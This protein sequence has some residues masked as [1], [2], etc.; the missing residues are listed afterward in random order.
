MSI[1]NKGRSFIQLNQQINFKNK[2][3]FLQ[4]LHGV[5]D[6]YADINI[7]NETNYIILQLL[8]L[9]PNLGNVK[10]LLSNIKLFINIDVYYKQH[11][12][13]ISILFHK[14]DAFKILHEI[15]N[16]KDIDYTYNQTIY[17]KFHNWIAG[18]NSY[19]HGLISNIEH[20]NQISYNTKMV[21][22]FLLGWFDTNGFINSSKVQN[23]P[24]ITIECI[25]KDNVSILYDLINIRGTIR[26]TKIHLNGCNAVDFLS[27]IYD[28]Y[29]E[30]RFFNKDKYNLYLEWN[31]YQYPQERII[32][33]SF[34]KDDV[35]AV[36]PTKNRHS[37]VG[38][39]LTIIKKIKNISD[40]I[41]MYDTG[42][43]VQPEYGY[44]TKIVP[45]SSIV[46]TGYILANSVGIIDGNFTGTLK[47]VL[48]KID[49]SM[50]DIV[51]PCKIAQL[52]IDKSIHYQMIEESNNNLYETNRGSGEFG[53]TNKL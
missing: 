44:Y 24:E 43:I 38:Y 30:T 37:D 33:C 34:Y 13:F 11:N 46:K 45:R 10:Q 6:T 12:K 4:F 32:K 40:D 27:K 49:K 7:R 35:L 52:I 20:L 5:I 8:F 25:N 51:L 28:T 31:K 3:D 42:I 48:I 29:T 53:S 2:R 17:D 16:N 39:D 26:N 47:I 18:N 9:S 50:P 14:Q 36:N 19:C 21:S 1:Y 23:I 15:Y 41:I 22:D